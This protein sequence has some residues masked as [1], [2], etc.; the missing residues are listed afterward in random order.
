MS[1]GQISF[2]QNSLWANVFGE[3]SLGKCCMSKCRITPKQVGTTPIVRKLVFAYATEFLPS[4]IDIFGVPHPQYKI[5]HFPIL[6][7]VCSDILHLSRML[8]TVNINL[9]QDLKKLKY[10]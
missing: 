8:V 7:G 4:K 1:Y 10:M 6:L 3:M 5:K 2:G 9:V